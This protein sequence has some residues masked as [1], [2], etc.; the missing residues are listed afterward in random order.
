LQI[1]PP[2]PDVPPVL[3]ASSPVL[4]L[5]PEPPLA[6]F[7]LPPLLAPPADG[8]EPP[9]P[10]R[11]ISPSSAVKQAPAMVAES[12][13]KQTTTILERIASP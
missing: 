11:P 10:G 9:L 4:V 3:V 5:P 8:A 13:H 1:V 2:E 7:E 6:V 12:T